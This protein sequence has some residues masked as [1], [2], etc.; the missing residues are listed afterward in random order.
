MLSS[1]LF[2]RRSVHKLWIAGAA[3]ASGLILFTASPARAD[4]QPSSPQL[5]PGNSVAPPF[6]DLLSGAGGYA[7]NSVRGA[8]STAMSGAGSALSGASTA[9]HEANNGLDRVRR[10]TNN[11]HVTVP[12]DGSRPLAQ[13]R[14]GTNSPSVLPRSAQDQPP[15]NVTGPLLPQMPQTSINDGDGLLGGIPLLT[16]LLPSGQP[17][18]FT[19]GPSSFDRPTVA[20]AE[21]LPLLGGILPAPGTPDVSDVSGLPGGGMA[22]LAPVAGTHHKTKP[23][24]PAAAP[25]SATPSVAAASTP[26]ATPSTAA[27]S[28]IAADPRLHEEPID[29]S[30]RTFS[31][32]GRPVAGVDQQFK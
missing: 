30:E 28:S 4:D 1:E 18:G 27:A 8:G 9:A 21:S 5:L 32:D 31:P 13:V 6:G 16:G 12:L 3:A 11:L 2:V 23:S 25:S 24:T 15:A 26:A 14:P 7:L 29:P 17:Q 19:D 22:V 20:E 10:P